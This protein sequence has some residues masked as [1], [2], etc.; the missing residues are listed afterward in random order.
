MAEVELINVTK[1]FGSTEV[2]HGVD[3][4]IHG[5]EFIVLVG[6]SGCGKSTLLR[7]IAGLESLT[8][9]EIR[10]D[11]RT[12]NRVPPS[13]R[14]V[15]MVFQ[16]Y[17]LYPHMTVYDN[18]G[19][20]L[21]MKKWSKAKLD[22]KVRE[23][24]EVLE[25]TPF[26]D[27]RPAALSGGQRQRVAMGRAIVR[28]PDVFLFDEPL[29]NLDAQLRTQMRMELKKLHLKMKTTTIYVTHDQIEAMTLAD[30][31]VILQDGYIQQ[32]GTPIDVYEK[33]ASVFVAR[34]IGNP[35]AN[36]L[37]GVFHRTNGK[38]VIALGELK[39]PVLKQVELEEG[40][41]V[42]V[43]IRPDAIKAV[44]T[45]TRIAET[46]RF[47]GTVVVSEIVG[48][49]SLLEFEMGG[50]QMIAELEGRVLLRPG[51]S[52]ILIF[53]LNRILLFDPKTQSAIN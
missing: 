32:V 37:A 1:R 46:W 52:I 19:F 31:I 41:E 35:P 6:P 3:L 26:L 7:M 53:D 48:G 23:V 2:V 15:A 39:F 49:Q 36:I 51:A 13:E 44:D 17:A 10:I 27:R 18:M 5:G 25:L 21:K 8:A 11:K 16:N 45:H 42:L 40:Q 9:G 47:Q 28:N 14:N 12:V 22:E 20:S 29:S 4:Q 38:G 24:A 43:G 30:R 33:P 34:F 50:N